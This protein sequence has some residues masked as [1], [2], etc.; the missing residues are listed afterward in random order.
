VASH[1][2]RLRR[3]GELDRCIA[4]LSG[5]RALALFTRVL[6][7]VAESYPSGEVAQWILQRLG[8][9]QARLGA[10]VLAGDASLARRRMLD[11]IRLIETGFG[12]AGE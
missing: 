4:E 11:H 12:L 2:E 6:G 1:A 10:A 9:H 7:A 8:E 5:N 3:S